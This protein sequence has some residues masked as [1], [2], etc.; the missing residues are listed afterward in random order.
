MKYIKINPT[1]TPWEI[2]C[3]SINSTI[4]AKSLLSPTPIVVKAFDNE[5]LRKIGEHLLNFCNVEG[6]TL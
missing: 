5:E 3:Q 4:E 2:A 1:D 6:G